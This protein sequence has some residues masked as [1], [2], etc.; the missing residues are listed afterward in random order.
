MGLNL[1]KI[2]STKKTCT[3]FERSG[4]MK[5]SI[6]LF[7]ASIL[8]PVCMAASSRKNHTEKSDQPVEIFHIYPLCFKVAM[9]TIQ[10]LKPRQA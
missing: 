9:R 8:H 10:Q 7:C 6:Y 3:T 4:L 1:F 2:S 5:E